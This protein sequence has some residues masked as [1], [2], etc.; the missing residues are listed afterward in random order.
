MDSVYKSPRKDRKTRMFAREGCVTEAHQCN[1][2]P[3]TASVLHDSVINTV[4][5]NSNRTLPQPQ[6]GN[7]DELLSR[8]RLMCPAPEQFKHHRAHL[9]G[10]RLVFSWIRRD[11]IAEKQYYYCYN[12][13]C[14][15]I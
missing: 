11:R 15:G 3:L 13:C 7:E 14:P 6:T 12:Y 5:N 2:Y 1:T 4:I 9:H 8:Q 10:N